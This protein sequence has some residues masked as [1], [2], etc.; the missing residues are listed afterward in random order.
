[1]VENLALFKKINEEERN[2]EYPKKIMGATELRQMGFP[3]SVV[4]R[5]ARSKGQRFCW[6]SNPKNPRSPL[7]FD[8]EEFEKWRQS[9][10]R[11]LELEV[12]E[13]RRRK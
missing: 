5:A 2:M 13:E 10:A 9:Q 1:M 8:T 3:R 6:R 12:P 11:L 7:L 4:D